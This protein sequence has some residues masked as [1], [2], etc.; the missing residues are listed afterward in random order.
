MQEKF[1]EP[2]LYAM[3]SREKWAEAAAILGAQ[4]NTD[5]RTLDMLV[6]SLVNQSRARAA[7]LAVNART[8]QSWPKAIEAFLEKYEKQAGLELVREADAVFNMILRV[9]LEYSREFDYWEAYYY[10][11]VSRGEAG[12]SDG[13]I[14]E[15][16]E[17]QG[18]TLPLPPIPLSPEDLTISA[19]EIPGTRAL[20]FEKLRQRTTLSIPVQQL[21][22]NDLV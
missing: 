18:E 17:K 15:V 14:E 7:E 22:L 13:V 12:N 5:S 11:N 4:K 3:P 2:E 16:P 8:R 21:T 9:F 1:A 6:R 10:L 19:L 20:G